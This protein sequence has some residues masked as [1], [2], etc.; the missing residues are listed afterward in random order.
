MQK[1]FLETSLGRPKKGFA[2]KAR[3]PLTGRSLSEIKV[4]PKRNQA[5]SWA[6][7]SRRVP[8][9]HPHG[10][11]LQIAYGCA[12]IKIRVRGVTRGALRVRTAAKT[13]GFCPF[14]AV[15]APFRTF[16]PRKFDLCTLYFSYKYYLL[17]YREFFKFFPGK[18]RSPPGC[19]QSNPEVILDNHQK[20]SDSSG[21][22]GLFCN[23]QL[24]LTL[25]L[26]LKPYNSIKSAQ[27]LK[28]QQLL[29]K[30]TQKAS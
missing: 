19:P 3:R 4:P 16:L 12:S 5:E 7:Q 10:P 18:K 6:A 29:A 20:W 8:S 23:Y 15:F 30:T 28:T 9:R 21:S 27:P 25:L 2:L 26:I 24:F 1:A 13:A 11:A 17:I 14:L 22:K